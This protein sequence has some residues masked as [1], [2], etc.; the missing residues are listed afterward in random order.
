MPT[1]WGGSALDSALVTLPKI[2]GCSP[3]KPGRAAKTLN[4][5]VLRNRAIVLRRIAST[6]AFRPSIVI[7]RESKHRSAITKESK[8]AS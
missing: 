6:A 1:R 7:A 3:A 8:N 2:H 4:F 5:L